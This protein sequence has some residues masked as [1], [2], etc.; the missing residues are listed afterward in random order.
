MTKIVFIKR[1][2]GAKMHKYVSVAGAA[3]R[4]PL[5]SLEFFAILKKKM[6]RGLKLKK[7]KRSEGG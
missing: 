3:S 6:E 7:K 5:E 2:F 4:T 1:N